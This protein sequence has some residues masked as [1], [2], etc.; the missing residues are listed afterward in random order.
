MGRYSDEVYAQYAREW[1][2]E[3]EHDPQDNDHGPEPGRVVFRNSRAFGDREKPNERRLRGGADPEDD[4]VLALDDGRALAR[5]ILDGPHNYPTS[6][7][8]RVDGISY[9]E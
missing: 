6:G 4:D 3:R 8:T 7:E 2:Q 1:A 9:Y 5:R